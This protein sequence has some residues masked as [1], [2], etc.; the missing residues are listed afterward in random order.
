MT[1]K[2][3]WPLHPNCRCQTVLVDP[4]DT[5]FANQ[6]RTAAVIRPIDKGPYKETKSDKTKAYKTPTKVK[7]KS[8][9]ER[10]HRHL[11]HATAEYSDV[12]AKWA[13]DSNTSLVEAMGEQRAAYF[14]KQLDQFNRD[15]QQILEQC[16]AETR[17]QQW[18]PVDKLKDLKCHEGEAEACGKRGE[19]KAEAQG[20]GREAEADLQASIAKAS[21]QP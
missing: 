4:E 21:L 16:C 1:R 17:E 19:G 11:R 5:E 13:G 8:S 6:A 14:K 15:P 12:L 7:A 10:R 3:D 18:I 2:P 9:T 20:S